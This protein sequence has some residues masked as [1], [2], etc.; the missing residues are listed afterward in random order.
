V[1]AILSEIRSTNVE[2]ETSSFGLLDVNVT[3][4]LLSA[5]IP[6]LVLNALSLS[7]TGT[8]S[9]IS[10]LLHTLSI[11]DGSARTPIIVLTGSGSGPIN[12][13]KSTLPPAFQNATILTVDPWQAYR[14]VQTFQSS[15][16]VD[17][18]VIQRYQDDFNSSRLSTL[19]QAIKTAFSPSS[20]SATSPKGNATSVTDVRTRSALHIMS[21]ATHAARS[22]LC[23]Q[24][25]HSAY[26]LAHIEAAR[27][28]IMQAHESARRLLFASPS[29]SSL[30]ASSSA[31]DAVA[32]SL[33][34]TEKV[35]KDTLDR[36][37]W[38]RLLYA[39][40]DV[41]YIVSTR[42]AQAWFRELEPEVNTHLETLNE[43]TNIANDSS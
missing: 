13:A 30:P 37:A 14:A 2:G 18:N 11:K 5:D 40:G 33:A 35:L 1:P 17:A 23:V 3:K 26:L 4:A 7:S 41:E 8:V 19:T 34:T 21:L 28:Q 10:A 39:A 6:I 15:G 36:L 32:R 29:S 43:I 27:S 31:P 22:A 9:T 20:S 12:L 42:A 25:A 16:S 38:W 24:R